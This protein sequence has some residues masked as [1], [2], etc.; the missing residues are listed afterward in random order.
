MHVRYVSQRCA[1]FKHAYGNTAQREGLF[2][3]TMF[4]A[5]CEWTGPT[6]VCVHTAIN[7]R[8]STLSLLSRDNLA[9]G[10]TRGR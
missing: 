10:L 6:M 8:L 4:T 3:K 7:S 9:L 2:T 1:G 5:G